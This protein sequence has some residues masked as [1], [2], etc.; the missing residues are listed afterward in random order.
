MALRLVACGSVDDG[1][2]TLIG[3]LLYEARGVYDDQLAALAADSRR[4][5]TQGDALDFALLLDGLAA[6]RE[7]SITIDVA[8]RYFATAKRNYI[9][10]DAPGHEQYTRNMVTGASTA[11]AAVLLVDASK[12]LVSQTRRHACLVSLM[13]VSD[14]AFVVSKMDLVGYAE[15]RYRPI[16]RACRELAGRLGLRRAHVLPA[17]AL[18]GDNV[19]SAGARMPWF[20][21]PTLLGYLESVTP[22]EER[23]DTLPLR[24]PVQLANRPTPDFRGFCG[25]VVSGVVRPG[26]RVR[27]EPGG[28]EAVVSRIVTREGDLPVATSGQS[29]TLTLSSEIDVA[30]GDVIC[31]ADAAAGVADQFEATI[32]WLGDEPM[33]G[34]RPYLLKAGAMTVTAVPA[35]PKYKLNV[36]NLDRLAARHL[37]TNDIGVCNL[38]LDRPI[39]FDPY[40]ENREMGAFILIDRVSN[41]TVGAGMLRFALRRAANIP[42]HRL[43]VDQAARGLAKGQKPCIV[44]LTGL[45]G[46]GKST[47]ANLLDRRL[48]ELGRHAYVLD[49]DNVRHG[50]NRDLG[51]TA[52]DRVENVRRVAEV[53]RLLADAGLIVIV[54]L[55]SPFR[56]ERRAARELMAPGE[57]IEVFVDTPLDVA[58]RR[59]PKGLYAKARRGEL[60]NFT[61]IDSPY[62]APGAPELRVETTQE[63]AVEACERILRF[64]RDNGNVANDGNP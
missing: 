62:E 48:F 13:G 31:A 10:A 46:A 17:S 16:E 44:W 21:G 43:E 22:E 32:V 33:L 28:R 63:S 38:A 2:S 59:D 15:D 6:E 54:S 3:R 8:H 45:S 41:D 60:A 34:G 58:E 50:L 9:V 24:I 11:D 55:I 37:E 39:A 30:R 27:V 49:G 29:V 36:D 64:L 7:Q 53:A 52:A 18:H 5:G 12:G 35:A 57:F 47:I 40:A 56:N 61:G 1:K 4:F 25:T 23:L 14:V 20:R 42:R 26:D 19:V 51:F